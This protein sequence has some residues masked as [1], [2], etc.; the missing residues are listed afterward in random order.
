MREFQ[1]MHGENFWSNWPRED[2]SGKDE[3]MAKT[4]KN[5]EEKSEMSKRERRK[6]RTKRALLKD[7]VRVLSLWR[8]VKS[9]VNGETWRVV[10]IFL[11]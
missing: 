1:A 8:P 3:R 5:E 4:E 6:K 7:D 2:K 9:L 11:G 10:V